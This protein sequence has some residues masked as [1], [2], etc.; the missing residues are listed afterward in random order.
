MKVDLD[1]IVVQIGD[2]LSEDYGYEDLRKFFEKAPGSLFELLTHQYIQAAL[3]WQPTDNWIRV[4]TST[5][6]TYGKYEVHRKGCKKTHYE[7]WNGTSWAYNN[8]DI[9]HWKPITPDPLD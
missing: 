8:K 7:T 4:T 5:P 9:T 6:S 3:L 2:K 1:T